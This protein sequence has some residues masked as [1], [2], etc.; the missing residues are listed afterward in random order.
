MGA[1]MVAGIKGIATLHFDGDTRRGPRH[2]HILKELKKHGCKPTIDRYGNI[3]VE[4]G[5]GKRVI[6]FSSHLDVDPKIS[7]V[8]FKVKRSGKRTTINGVLDNAVGCYLNLLLAQK[9]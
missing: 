5:S 6:L 7:K 8:A 9:G 3:W 1:W 4:R 2:S